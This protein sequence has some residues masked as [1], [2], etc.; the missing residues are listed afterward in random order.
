[1]SKLEEHREAFFSEHLVEGQ[2]RYIQG[3]P[4]G[5]AQALLE[6]LHDD[7]IARVVNMRSSQQSYIC[8]YLEDVWHFSPE[9]F[10][11]HVRIALKCCD[12]LVLGEND[13]H[14]NVLCKEPLPSSVWKATLDTLLFVDGDD[15]DY[16]TFEIIRAQTSGG[17]DEE[18]MRRELLDWIQEVGSSL[19]EYTERLDNEFEELH[20]DWADSED[21]FRSFDQVVQLLRKAFKDTTPTWLAGVFNVS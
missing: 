6:S 8:D 10:W 1:M 21:P 11:N 19:E 16:A 20:G 4:K 3:L 15:L 18:R 5:Q 9:A 17:P 12:G 14:L 13:F 7:E 2:H